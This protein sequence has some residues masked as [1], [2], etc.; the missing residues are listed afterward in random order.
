MKKNLTI[1]T[2]LVLVVFICSCNTINLDVRRGSGNVITEER[3]VESFE[4]IRME[5]G[6]RIDSDPGR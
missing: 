1:L 2:A 3:A 6:R 4:R 5:G